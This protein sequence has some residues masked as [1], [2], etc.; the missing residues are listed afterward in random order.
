MWPALKQ[1]MLK[2]NPEAADDTHFMCNYC[3]S[4][5]R[6]NKMPPRCVLNGLEVIP[7]PVEL[8]RLDCLSKQFIQ[9][10]KSYQTVVRLGTYTAKVPT[11]NSLQ[12]CKGTMFFLP[13]LPLEKTLQTLDQVS[14]P[15]VALASPE[16]Y[17]S[18]Q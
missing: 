15:N 8:T 6:S 11:Y 16:L 3:K 2:D 1:Y 7:I 10:A 5:I 13:L 9:R 14:E 12:A 4:K 18:S 17:R